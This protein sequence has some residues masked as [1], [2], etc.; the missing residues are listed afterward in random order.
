LRLT[1]NGTLL[2]RVAD[3][4]VS[5]GVE[6]VTVSL[7]GPPEVHDLI[8][9]QQGAFLRTV[10]GIKALA[11]ARVRHKRQ[12]PIMTLICTISKANYNT[13]ARIV[14]VALETGVDILQIQHTFFN[15]PA[16]VAQH[17]RLMSS[18]LAREWGIDPV[19]PIFDHEYYQNELGPK[20]MPVLLESLKEVKRQAHGRLNLVFNP[21]LPLKLIGP[22]YLDLD[23]PF[24][25]IC[26]HLWRSC[27]IYPDGTITPCFHVFIGNIGDEPFQKLW[28][29]P[30]MQRFRELIAR[31][32]L[33]PG[34]ARCCSRRF[35]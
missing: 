33:F 3:L 4:L 9:G 2:P 10:A 15:S 6:W 32:G 31:R 18:A 20:D 29:N 28:N 19:A 24:P 5:Q 11:E 16:N 30:K 13:L 7:D 8:R 25:S 35:S 14:P 1:T 17:N 26:K 21:N 12:A 34:C 22:Y 27:R 23:Y